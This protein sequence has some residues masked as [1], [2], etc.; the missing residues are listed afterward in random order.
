MLQNEVAQTV[1]RWRKGKQQRLR[2]PF[3]RLIILSLIFYTL[4]RCW[5][6]FSFLRQCLNSA[7]GFRYERSKYAWIMSFYPCLRSYFLKTKKKKKNAEL[8]QLLLGHEKCKL[9]LYQRRDLL[10]Y[11]STLEGNGRHRGKLVAET[12]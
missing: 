11:T 5:H 1:T 4:R 10:L 8:F 3:I 7:L 9:K 6:A 12:S 2:I